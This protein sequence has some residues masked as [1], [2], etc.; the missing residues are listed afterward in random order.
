MINKTFRQFIDRILNDRCITDDDVRLLQRDLLP[1][2]ISCQDEA[3]MLIALDRA[4]RRRSRRWDDFLV[5][6]VTEFA[7][8]TARPTG[9]VMGGDA[10]W[11]VSSLTAGGEETNNALR[12]AA[13]VMGEAQM[14][15][16]LL[17]DFVM[18]AT[19]RHAEAISVTRDLASRSN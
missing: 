4:I 10:R 7:V 19:R 12:I 8:W 11:L 2:G 9:I 3:D 17:G 1:H 18:A 14:A 5:Q 13:A 6:A 16:D 15:D